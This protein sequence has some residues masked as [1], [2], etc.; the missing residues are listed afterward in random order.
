[1]TARIEDYAL[2]GNC[3]TAALVSKT[4]SIDW[5]CFPRF[6]GAACFAALLGT[7]ENGR[8]QISPSEPV[9]A[10]RR[11]Y[12]DGTL[13]L[14][15]TFVTEQGEAKLI[16]F[17]PSTF[18][19]SS[20]ARIVVGV[21]GSVAFNMDL[22]M[23]FDYGHTVPW[24]ER[25]EA[26]TLTAVAGPDM[27]VL[28]TPAVLKPRAK[29]T[30]SQFTVSAGERVHFTLT[31]Q[32][33]HEPVTAAFDVGTAL[34]KTDYFWREFSG[35]CPDV[36]PWTDL[37]KRSL[38]TLKALTYLPTGGIV[39]AATTSLPEQLGGQRNW[40][41]RY[42]WLRDATI[43]LMAFMKLGYFDEAHAWREWLARSVAGRPD[44][45][46]IMYGLAGER[47]LPELEIPWLAGY[48]GASPVR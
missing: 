44:Q 24:V 30:T 4:G 29:H 13:I 22:A 15:T 31:H 16:D 42:C 38:I 34:T 2:L 3:R 11:S 9:Q 43:T 39:A 18:R 27:L 7:S 40:D 14:E 21:K 23:R 25:Y 37:V 46:Q 36:G 35:R 8:W 19:H 6:D 47:R 32:P 5:L 41:Y 12:Q 1:M 45:M 20:V 17:M 26:Q 10:V 28:R 33:S 48:E